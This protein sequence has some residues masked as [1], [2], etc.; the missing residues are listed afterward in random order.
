MCR[1]DKD[2]ETMEAIINEANAKR[3]KENRSFDSYT[4]GSA[5]ASYTL[6]CR[7]ADARA[8]E[9]PDNPKAQE[10][11]E[12]YKK[13]YGDWVNKN[14]ANDAGHV[15]IMISGGSNYNMKAHERWSARNDKLMKE[16]IEIND[17]FESALKPKT[18]DVIHDGDPD[19]LERL[20]AKLDK[21]Q[22]QHNAYIEH[23]KKARKECTEQLPTYVLQNSNGRLKALRDR[24]ARLE[25][26]KAIQE[27]S[28]PKQV[29]FEGGY[30]IE[31]IEIGRV[32][33]FFDEKP[34]EAMRTKLKGHGWNWSFKNMAWQRQ[35]T[36]NAWLDA[37]VLFAERII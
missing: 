26:T 18:D 5:T 35:N 6:A 20:K 15:S 28:G 17:R 14:N 34:E 24:I 36:A 25:K 7:N 21:E 10:A 22:L 11:A 23:N 31:N 37:N 3:A 1:K 9:F 2:R 8:A 29:D 16:Y 19:A 12:R 32:Q 13:Q 33:I 27:E 30:V 4:Q